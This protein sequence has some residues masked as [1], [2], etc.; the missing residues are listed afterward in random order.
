V[1]LFVLGGGKISIALS[2]DVDTV[3]TG[4]TM[5]GQFHPLEE[6]RTT[7]EDGRLTFELDDVQ[8]RGVVLITSKAER[9]HARQ[10]MSAA[11]E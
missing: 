2:A 1:G 10:L 5:G 9:E 8:A 4:E 7:R 11:I 6:V 3:E